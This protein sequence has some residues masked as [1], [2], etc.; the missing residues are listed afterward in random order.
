MSNEE[1]MFTLL[2][3]AKVGF[4]TSLHVMRLISGE[5]GDQS[6]A[7]LGPSLRSACLC[8]QLGHDAWLGLVPVLQLSQHLRKMEP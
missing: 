8:C 1:L 3:E 2:W 5:L 6:S 7:Y 4:L